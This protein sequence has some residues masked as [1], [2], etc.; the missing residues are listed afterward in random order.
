MEVLQARFSSISFAFLGKTSPIFAVRSGYGPN[1]E[2]GNPSLLIWV[3]IF[4]SN[5][6]LISA[7]ARSGFLCCL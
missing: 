2:P 4:L 1:G 7:I 3:E 5:V 6:R